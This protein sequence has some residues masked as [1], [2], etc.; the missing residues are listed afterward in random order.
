MEGKQLVTL[1]LCPLGSPVVLS[2]GVRRQ[3]D[4]E[5]NKDLGD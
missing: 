4:L 5:L 3:R 2:S 1:D